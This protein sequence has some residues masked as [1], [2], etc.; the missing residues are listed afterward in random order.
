[1][2]IYVICPHADVPFGGV[3]KAYLHVD[4]LNS[5]GFD[6]FIVHAKPGFRCTWF[7]NQTKIRYWGGLKLTNSDIL[8]VPPIPPSVIQLAPGVRKVILNQAPYWTFEGASFENEDKPNACIHDEVMATLVISND[9]FNYLRFAFPRAR[10]IQFRQGVDISI[11]KYVSAKK[12]Q[13]AF[14][15]RR[16]FFLRQVIN[17]L[18]ARGT[19]E[20][21]NLVPIAGSTEKEVAQI[22]GESCIFLAGS[23][24]EGFGLPAAEAMACGCAV[25]GYHAG[26][27][28]EFLLPEFAFPVATGEVVA[29]VKAVEDVI[30][31][32]SGKPEE[33]ESKTKLAASFI[34][35]NYSLTQE[36]ETLLAAWQQILDGGLA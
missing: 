30:H 1:M 33:L 14:M 10:I 27:G 28:K 16:P 7:E 23:T 20:D 32:S 5:G 26:G 2:S 29:F 36:R 22:M 6:A 3:R 25:V 13:I 8:V 31:L 15:P 24:H 34:A 21:F 17:M 12:R 35:S 11:F 9:G 18:K 19:L 4:F